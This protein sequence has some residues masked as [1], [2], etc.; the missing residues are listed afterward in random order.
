MIL[1]LKLEMCGLF[2]MKGQ[3]RLILTAPSPNYYLFYKTDL[4]HHCND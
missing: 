3:E 1:I 4:H 2:V